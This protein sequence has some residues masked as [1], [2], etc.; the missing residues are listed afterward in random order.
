MRLVAV[1][2]RKVGGSFVITIPQKL[3]VELEWKDQLEIIVGSHEGAVLAIPLTQAVSPEMMRNID[4]IRKS[5]K[6]YI[7]HHQSILDVLGK[8]VE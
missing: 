2:L 3:I 8:G 1:K 7:S 4:K 5:V 6:E